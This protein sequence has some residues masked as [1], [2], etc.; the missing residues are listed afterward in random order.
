MKTTYTCADAHCPRCQKQLTGASD[1]TGDA[2]PSPDDL[3][4]CAYCGALLVFNNDLTV[5]EA[6]RDDVAKLEPMTAWQLGQFQGAVLLRL[7]QE[8]DRDGT[9]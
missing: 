3:S 8:R 9:H 5:R 4:V 7:Q 1:P 6:T 2:T